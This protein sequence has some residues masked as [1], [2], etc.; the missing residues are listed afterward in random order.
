MAKEGILDEQL[1]THSWR[2]KPLNI[3]FHQKHSLA[4]SSTTLRRLPL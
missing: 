1:Q 2:I 3:P 4:N